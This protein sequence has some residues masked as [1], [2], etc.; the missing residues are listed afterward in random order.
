MIVDLHHEVES[1]LCLPRVMR[2]VAQGTC[3]VEP[4]TEKAV[5]LAQVATKH[6][7]MEE[8]PELVSLCKSVLHLIGKTQE[9]ESA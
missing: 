7:K 6:V 8:V 4:L 5:V 1:S 2:T 3:A 9:Q